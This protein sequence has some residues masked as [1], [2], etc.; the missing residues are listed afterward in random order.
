MSPC[1]YSV[2]SLIVGCRG[3]CNYWVG[4]EI[5]LNF[6]SYGEGVCVGGIVVGGVV[7]C[8]KKVKILLE[9]C[10]KSFNELGRIW[11]IR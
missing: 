3:R 9:I 2:V 10:A 7:K 6:C 8:K 5:F 1:V 4:C 11:E